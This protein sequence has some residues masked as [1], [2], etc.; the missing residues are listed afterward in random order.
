MKHIKYLMCGI[1][2]LAG[3]V[4]VMAA[5]PVAVAAYPTVATVVVVGVLGYLVGYMLLT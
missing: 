2:F 5:I 1:G 4:G 3:A